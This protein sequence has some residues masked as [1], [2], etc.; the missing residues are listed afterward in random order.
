MDCQHL[1]LKKLIDTLYVCKEYLKLDG[2]KCVDFIYFALAP[3]R[4]GALPMK[5]CAWS[6][7]TLAS[8]PHLGCFL[9]STVSLW[10]RADCW[11]VRICV[12]ALWLALLLCL[13]T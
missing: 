10:F 13:I 12:V 11:L 5:H 3:S 4:K 9:L 7:Y 8:R 1:T 2:E 6:M